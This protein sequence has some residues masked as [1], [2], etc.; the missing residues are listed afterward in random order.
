MKDSQPFVVEFY[1]TDETGE[2]LTAVE[3]SLRVFAN[4][5]AAGSISGLKAAAI[6]S[7]VIQEKS[8][9]RFTFKP[10]HKLPSAAEIEI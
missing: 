3:K 7:K 8:E 6:G 10:V 5:M 9:L 2:Y 1:A 4:Q